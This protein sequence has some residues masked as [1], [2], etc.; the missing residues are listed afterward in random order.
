MV[1][2][3]ILPVSLIL[4]AGCAQSEPV[5]NMTVDINA[6][7]VEAQSTVD[8]YGENAAS[9]D[10]Q[11]A[12]AMGSTNDDD[13]AI[14]DAASTNA[15][16]NEDAPLDPPAPGTPGGL[17]D[18]RTPV[19]EARF[20]QDSAQGAANVVQTYYAFLGSRR[21]PEARALVQS[22]SKIAERDVAAFAATFDRYSE[23]HANVGAPG[24]IDAGAGQRYVTVPVQVYARL[25]ADRAP[26]YSIGT[27]TL[28]RAG[29]IDGATAEQ[30]KWKISD[31][32]LKPAPAR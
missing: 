8:A 5:D 3:L 27:V 7:A 31:I 24:R 18:D 6:A 15:V 12:R 20:T 10:A 25:K 29:D 21:F 22:G 19:S 26:V 2:K 32:A 4:L 11:D 13:D 30:R 14:D 16:G 1:S 28:H 23:Y 9:L 17:P